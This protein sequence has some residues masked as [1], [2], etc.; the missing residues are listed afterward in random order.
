MPPN[1]TSQ[2]RSLGEYLL[3]A[4]AILAYAAL[5]AGIAYILEWTGT[6]WSLG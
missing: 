3:V 5:I 1:R 2:R 6:M 4:A